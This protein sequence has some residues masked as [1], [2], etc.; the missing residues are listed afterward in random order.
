[1][2][3]DDRLRVFITFCLEHKKV[4]NSFIRA[5]QQILNDSLRNVIIKVPQVLDF[6]NKRLLF[7]TQIK[8]IQKKYR[9]N[10]FDIE[11]KRDQVFADSFE[12]LEHLSPDKWKGKMNI[13]FQ[14]E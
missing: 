5:N 13:E 11:V 2:R 10:Y 14:D 7:R 3:K 6:D 8:K 9:M 4:I 12:Q 1:M